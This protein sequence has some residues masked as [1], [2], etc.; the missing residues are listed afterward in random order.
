VETRLRTVIG[1]T[2]LLAG[3]ASRPSLPTLSDYTSGAST[4]AAEASGLFESEVRSDASASH[5]RR[6][7]SASIL[8]AAAQWRAAS[9]KA[10]VES[11]IVDFPRKPGRTIP[12][13]VRVRLEGNRRNDPE[14]RL[15][16]D[17]LFDVELERKGERW[18]VVRTR[19]AEIPRIREGRPH[20]REIG[21]EIG[22]SS[23]RNETFDPVEATNICIPATHH[24]PGVAVADF[25]GDGS[26][27]ILLPGAHPRLFLNDGHGRFRDATAGS[28]LDRLAPGEAAGA[29][30]A[31]L[32]G[33]TRPELFLTY[34]YSECRL[35][36][37]DGGGK[38]HDITSE[39]GLSGLSTMSTSAVF[40]DA[41][42]DG[43]LDLF[44]A[45]YGDARETGPAYS[46]KNGV[47]SRFFHNVEK[48][49]RP[50]FVDETASAGFSDRGWAF[51][52][53]ACDF[54]GDGDDDLYVANDFGTNCLYENVSTPGVPRF[55]EIAKSAGVLDDGYGMGVAWGD[56]DGDGRFD[57]HVSDFASPYR[58][59][60]RSSRL[61]MPPVPALVQAV[62]RPIVVPMLL[63]RCEGDGLYRNRGNG[64]FEK[65]SAAAG[66]SDGGWAWGTEF[67]DLDG[68]GR[69]DLLVVNGMWQAAP[70]GSSDEVKFWNKMSSEGIAFHDGFW[71][72][73]DFG[74][75]GMASRTAKHLYR[76]IG[77]GKFAEDAYL[78]GFDTRDDTRGLAYGDLDGDGGPEI[79]LSTFRGRL[80]V[81]ANGWKESRR[82]TVRL[83]GS[84]AH[85]REAI[86]T[87]VF[88]QSGGRMQIREVRAGSSYL[89]CSAKELYFGLGSAEKADSIEVR[90]PDGKI[91]T[92]RNVA[93]GKIVWKEG[94]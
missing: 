82:L 42:R 59:M 31:D 21:P 70:E 39:S 4:I 91:E 25:D 47:G 43:R 38:F 1:A 92:R 55:R 77:N 81:Y 49:G 61:P 7:E 8:D 72:G 54:D 93:A 2:L 48:G 20:L 22:L 18:D 6:P 14:M 89:S 29:V 35:L 9:G 90:W 32:D 5:F 34:A 16:A 13:R 87:V 76:N 11:W 19:A 37:N 36:E 45:V 79:V 15:F 40:F 44:V 12:M 78:E 88:L 69:E 17:E 85:N 67:V 73:I 58:W 83:E 66:V 71:G 3:C 86:G 75:D 50:F 56:Y 26:L 74:R 84:S 64:T 33:D 41:D 10:R 28:G 27:D 46:G 80:L 51:A 52:A 62:A 68:D 60:I 94:T 65:T 63:R 24:H 53:S 57:L 23:A 30:A